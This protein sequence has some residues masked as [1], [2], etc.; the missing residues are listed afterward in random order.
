[1]NFRRN[2]VTDPVEFPIY[3][4]SSSSCEE[5]STNE[6]KRKRKREGEPSEKDNVNVYGV[7]VTGYGNEIYRQVR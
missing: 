2:C 1:M 6:V 4:R 7:Y 5:R 3:T